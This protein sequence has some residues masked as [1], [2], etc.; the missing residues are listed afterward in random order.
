MWKVSNKNK[1]INIPK[2]IVIL[3]CEYLDIQSYEAFRKLNKFNYKKLPPL[4]LLPINNKNP[5]KLKGHKSWINALKTLPDG[6]LVSSSID[7]IRIWDLTNPTKPIVLEHLI[8]GES[9]CELELLPDGRLVSGSHGGN[10]RVWDLTNP[11]NHIVL[12]G[13]TDRV[14]ALKSLPDGRLVSGS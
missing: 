1:V 10:I 2:G 13:H 7:S 6:R 12:R 5:L 3:I 8:R 9:F 11:A 14:C 4:P